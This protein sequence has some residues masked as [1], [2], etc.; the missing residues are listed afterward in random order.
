[1]CDRSVYTDPLPEVALAAMRG[2]MVKPDFISLNDDRSFLIEIAEP[3][4]RLAAFTALSK[5]FPADADWFR[6]HVAGPCHTHCMNCGKN[7]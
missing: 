1:M 2:V 7:P 3:R 5:A 4:H 6:I